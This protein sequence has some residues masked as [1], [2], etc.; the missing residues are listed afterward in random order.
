MVCPVLYCTRIFH[1]AVMLSIKDLVRKG[2]FLGRA[3]LI[4]T[5]NQEKFL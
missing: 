1:E 2:I 5:V 3:V 4:D